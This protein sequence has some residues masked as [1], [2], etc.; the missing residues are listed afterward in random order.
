[1]SE[2]INHQEALN[3]ALQQRRESN[4][5]RCYLD[6]AKREPDSEKVSLLAFYNR[7][8]D[9]AERNMALTNTV[10]G[11]HWNAMRQELKAMGIEVSR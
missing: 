4:L 1:M 7:V 5:A 10:S 11:A 6:L 9:Q 3:L 2:P 8:C